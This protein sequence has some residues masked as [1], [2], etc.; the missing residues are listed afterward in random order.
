MTV[1]LLHPGEM[2][3]ALG[4]LLVRRGQQVLWASDGRGDDT[5]RRA[6]AAGLDDAGTIRE[7]CGRAET[8]LSVCPP[9]AALDVA[10]TVASAGF[11][12]LYLDA[13]AVA[14]ATAREVASVLKAAG[15]TFVDGGIV[16]LP[17]RRAGST[18]LYLS[19]AAAQRVAHLFADT[20]LEAVV[21]SPEPGVASS[22]K[23]VYAAWTK[24][25]AALLLA[26][27]AAA[28][29]HGVE[30]AL[31]REWALSQPGLAARAEGA[32]AQAAT[33]GWRWVGEMEEIAATLAAAGLPDGFH[34]AAA[35][36]FGRSGRESSASADG[37]TL[38]EVVA[39]L[40]AGASQEPAC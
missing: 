5:A 8:I 23:T 36:V 6:E 21:L 20:N 29:V 38:D 2:G 30:D 19:G 17:P 34:L 14:P 40:L 3:A 28:R 10:R 31:R 9:H 24:G 37:R 33:K 39:H 12:G 4:A 13:N 22:L 32:A 11:R 27:V 15:A 25:S 1:G 7:I 16:G 35:E 26:A 18:R